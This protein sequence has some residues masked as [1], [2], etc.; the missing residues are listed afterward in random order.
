MGCVSNSARKG[1]IVKVGKVEEVKVVTTTDDLQIQPR[2]FV[3]H[4]EADILKDYTMGPKLGSGAFGS[5]RIGTHKIT[6]QQR[7]IKTIKKSS[8]SEDQFVKD[9]FFAEVEVLKTADHPNIVRLYEFYEDQLHFHLVTELVKG[10]ELFDYI[11]SSKNLSEPVAAHFFKQILSA[12]NYCH[13]NGIVHRDLKPENLLLDRQDSSATVK[14]ID[15]GT[16]TIIDQSKRLTHRYGTSYYIA[17]E[18]LKKNYDEKCDVWS[19]GVILYILLSGKPPFYGETDADILA[20]VEKGVYQMKG[21][22]WDRVSS[23]A[24]NL[25]K[26]MLNMDPRSRPTA[27]QCLESTWLT[28]M[29][30]AT[31]QDSIFTQDV[32]ENLTN[33]RAEKKLQHAVMSFI[34]TQLMNKNEVSQL[35]Q[36]FRALDTNG[37]GKLSKD[38]LLA[39]YKNTMGANQAEEEVQ[40]IMKEVDVDGNGFIDYSEFIMASAKRES[41]LS[42][43][44]LENAFRL[45]DNDNSGKISAKEIRNILGREVISSDE[46]WRD[47]VGQVD[48]NGDGEIDLREFTEM[49]LK[50]F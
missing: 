15:F 39:Q 23:N 4:K 30:D 37:D 9:K 3:I 46:V 28:L 49:M 5:V 25:I 19:C 13:T 34:A 1:A 26:S 11:V 47:L 27:A 20:R 50:L 16:S 6:M 12:V 7:A 43:Q 38:E 31:N 21:A 2:Q 22:T 42:K 17:P 29:P 36:A 18:V 10:G 41:L 33:F 48:Q 40:R 45:F 14:V 8:I 32:L 24:K 35:A 44:N